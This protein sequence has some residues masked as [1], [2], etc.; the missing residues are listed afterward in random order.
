MG[1]DNSIFVEKVGCAENCDD[2]DENNDVDEPIIILDPS[3]TER[4][5]NWTTQ[6]TEGNE[7]VGAT[8]SNLSWTYANTAGSLGF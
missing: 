1:Y 4:A 8:T 7:T 3:F 6:V 2:E 5:A